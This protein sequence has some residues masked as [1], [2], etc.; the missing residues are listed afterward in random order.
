VQKSRILVKKSF[1]PWKF[2]ALSGGVNS[3]ANK[4]NDLKIVSFDVCPIFRERQ[5]F[6]TSIQEFR[7]KINSLK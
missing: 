4:I 2:A 3:R 7:T 5:D 1:Q 6:F